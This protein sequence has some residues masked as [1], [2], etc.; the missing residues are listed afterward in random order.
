MNEI[1]LLIELEEEPSTEDKQAIAQLLKSTILEI[2]A[3]AD[4]YVKSASGSWLMLAWSAITTTANWLV[5]E[6]G[7]W[8]AGK[9]F[10]WVQ[11]RMSKSKSL[12]ASNEGENSSLQQGQESQESDSSLQQS[13]E[14]YRD[15]QLSGDEGLYE[16]VT[17]MSNLMEHPALAKSRKVTVTIAEYSAERGF[18]VSAS[19][20]KVKDDLDN[21]DTDFQINLMNSKEDFD[22]RMDL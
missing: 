12:P 2:Q 11:K 9:G 10:D 1:R 13:Q 19:L 14:S 16:M 4:I 15:E 17:R 18:G 3:D 6:F 22:S 20:T 5:P 21:V 7:S 8:L